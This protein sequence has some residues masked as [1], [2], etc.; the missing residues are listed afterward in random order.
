MTT[1]AHNTKNEK[2][3]EELKKEGKKALILNI[4]FFI[5]LFA[6]MFL[7]PLASLKVSIIVISIA[8]VASL[9]Y[10]YFT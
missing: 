4:I 6:G 9:L 1:V 5:V 10:I 3:K 8:F 2:N 7:V